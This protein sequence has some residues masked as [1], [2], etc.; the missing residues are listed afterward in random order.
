MCQSV[1]KYRGNN[2][3]IYL[4]TGHRIDL[5][6]RMLFVGGDIP[7]VE[8]L[9]CMFP[10]S[11]AITNRTRNVSK[12]TVKGVDCVVFITKALPHSLYWK[13][14][15]LIDGNVQRVRTASENLG[16]VLTAISE[17]VK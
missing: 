3:H 6:K 17:Q 11:K 15:N 7:A 14:D 2:S 16:L 13:V 12:N 1:E 4:K 10:N 8:K 5:T 9:R